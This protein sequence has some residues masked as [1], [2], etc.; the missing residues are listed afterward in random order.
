ML[1]VQNV[2][3]RGVSFW[4]QS[5]RDPGG[6]EIHPNICFYERLD[7]KMQACPEIWHV[8]LLTFY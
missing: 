5:L 4:Y 2:R 3:I 1:H 8:V 6:S 7:K